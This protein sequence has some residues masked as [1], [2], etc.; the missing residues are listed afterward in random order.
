MSFSYLPWSLATPMWNR[1]VMSALMTQNRISMTFD[2]YILD[3]NIDV[4]QILFTIC[5]GM[6]ENWWPLIQLLC[7]SLF[8]I[9]KVS[10]GVGDNT[11]FCLAFEIFVLDELLILSSVLNLIDAQTKLKIDVG[12]E[13]LLTRLYKIWDDT[14]GDAM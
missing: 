3:L 2:T 4:T 8:I 13:I 9:W 6:L 14:I 7:E 12:N 5:N 1:D 11:S 10:L